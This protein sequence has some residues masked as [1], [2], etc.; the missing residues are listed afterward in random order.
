MRRDRPLCR[1]CRLA[2]AST[3][4]RS[5]KFQL[6][7][8]MADT[9]DFEKFPLEVRNEIYA[10]LLVK[11]QKIPIKR[12]RENKQGK[13][14]CTDNHRNTRHPKEFYDRGQKR[15]VAAPLCAT[16]LLLVNKAI[17]QEATQVLYGFNQFKFEHAG[18]LLCF[19][20]CIG[21][22]KQHLRHLELI[23]RGILYGGSL[24]AMT[25]SVKL[26]GQTGGL[27]PLKI[28]HFA[29]CDVNDGHEARHSKVSIK[30][31]AIVCAPLLGFLKASF[32][33]QG[34]SYSAFDVVKIE[35]PP[36]SYA[37]GLGPNSHEEQH[38]HWSQCKT[39]HL[40]VACR[41]RRCTC[42]CDEAEDKN[43]GF[44]KE[45]KKEVSKMLELGAGQ[46]KRKKIGRARRPVHVQ[47]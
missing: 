42:L 11:T 7:P 17:S 38:A 14:V 32:E 10:H 43:R 28:L 3:L 16:S 18:A 4:K 1:I 45:F 9:G 2:Q 44:V 13:A 8:T 19:L 24:L 40:P 6:H 47:R 21:D 31:L 5:N 46:D 25:R 23:G 35:L 33:E 27:R 36:C 20:E 29:I 37:S 12:V 26:L 39:Y 15:W 34:L 30:A 22:A 41:L